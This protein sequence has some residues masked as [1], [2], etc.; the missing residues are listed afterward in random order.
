MPP[1]RSTDEKDG[2]ENE[3]VRVEEEHGAGLFTQ[4]M[5]MAK[6]AVGN[7]ENAS[8]DEL[9]V[10]SPEE[11]PASAE[12]SNE[13]K[14]GI[15]GMFSAP[16]KLPPDLDTTISNVGDVDDGNHPHRAQKSLSERHH[17][18]HVQ[19]L[20]AAA[21]GS[22]PP[23]LAKA[24]HAM[25]PA[26]VKIVGLIDKVSPPVL[27]LWRK[28][29]PVWNK[30]P[31]S[32]RTCSSHTKRRLYA[33][34]CSTVCDVLCGQAIRAVYGLALCFFGGVFP[35]IIAAAESFKHSG[36]ERAR[37][38]FHDLKQA[39]LEVY[40][41]NVQDDLRDDDNDG[42]AD[43]HQIS[44][45][46]LV[47]RKLVLLIRTIDPTV[48]QQAFIGIYQ[49]FIGVLATLKFKFAKSIALGLSIGNM[50]KRPLAV[51]LAPTLQH[52]LKPGTKFQRL[53]YSQYAART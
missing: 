29:M 48:L 30:L 40:K 5:K 26:V 28:S 25:E 50:A 51:V 6:D 18:D 49:G 11:S 4:A 3:A 39:A 52:V 34:I 13:S 46:E 10:E 45:Q 9:P 8:A 35:N 16:A 14:G 31:H 38:C 53:L 2:D 1:R 43:I 32:V 41:A 33:T 12:P 23:R 20:L 36:Y 7:V 47:S 19:A 22:A 37:T 42:V 24:I 17:S 27:N 44:R 15:M 21:E